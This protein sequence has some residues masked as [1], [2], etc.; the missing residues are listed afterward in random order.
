M[1]AAGL[2]AVFLWGTLCRMVLAP[3]VHRKYQPSKKFGI[4]LL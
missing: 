3:M 1:I 4:L 2:P